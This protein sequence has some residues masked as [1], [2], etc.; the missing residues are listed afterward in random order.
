M[1]KFALPLVALAMSASV[2]A[3]P[4]EP[5]KTTGFS[6]EQWIEDIIA[7]PHTALTVDEAIAAAQA[8]DVVGSTDGLQ[9]RYLQCNTA[10]WKRAPGRDAAACADDLARKGNNGVNCVI[11][12]NTGLIEM[13]RIGGAQVHAAKPT[14]VVN[15]PVPQSANCNDV[16]RTI[17]QI[18]DNCWRSDDTVLGDATCITNDNMDIWLDGGQA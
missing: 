16:A 8:A 12:S 4:S 3:A 10:G 15:L 6:F 7:N 5:S 2:A 14:R 9:K 13:C 1:V 17:G 18:F 11:P